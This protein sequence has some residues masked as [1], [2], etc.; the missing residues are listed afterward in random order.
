MTN[1]NSDLRRAT[2]IFDEEYRN[3]EIITIERN[4]ID[5]FELADGEYQTFTIKF[6]DIDKEYIATCVI[7]AKPACEVKS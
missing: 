5:S 1:N 4:E 7:E 3:C 2:A 6:Y